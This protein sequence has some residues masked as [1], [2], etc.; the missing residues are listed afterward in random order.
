MKN[1]FSF[2]VFAAIAIAGCASTPNASTSSLAQQPDVTTCKKI[3]TPQDQEGTVICGVDVEWA[4]FDR[5]I[6]EIYD[7]VTCRGVDMRTGISHRQS[8]TCMTR[9]Q[10]K[11]YDAHLRNKD[12]ALRMISEASFREPSITIPPPAEVNDTG[13]FALPATP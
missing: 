3:F 10:W 12:D 4:E 2:T 6:A 1:L 7:G 13:W 9:K 5:R 8:K 11:I